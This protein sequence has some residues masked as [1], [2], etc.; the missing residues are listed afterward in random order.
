MATYY[1]RTGGVAGSDDLDL[2]ALATKTFSQWRVGGPNGGEA[3]GPP[4]AGD[5]VLSANAVSVPGLMGTLSVDTWTVQGNGTFGLS[6]INFI[7]GVLTIGTIVI[8]GIQNLGFAAEWSYNPYNPGDPDAQSPFAVLKVTQTP[9]ATSIGQGSIE[10]ATTIGANYKAT[11]APFAVEAAAGGVINA[12]TIA[13]DGADH[14]ISIVQGGM[15]NVSDA[16]NDYQSLTVSQAGTATINGTM[17]PAAD[18]KTGPWTN[19]ITVTDAR[20]VFTANATLMVGGGSAETGIRGTFTVQNGATANLNRD[21]TVGDKTLDVGIVSVTGKGSTLKIDGDLTLGNEGL[22]TMSLTNGAGLTVFGNVEEGAKAGAVL[23]S[24]ATAIN[25]AGVTADIHGDWKIGVAAAR[26]DTIGGGAAV[27]VD[28]ELNLG[29]K[30][31]G[32]GNLTV[33]GANTSLVISAGNAEVTIGGAGTGVFRLDQGTSFDAGASDVTVADEAGD[34]GQSQLDIDGAEMTAGNL[35]IGGGGDGNLTMENGAVLT[36]L[37]DLSLG[38]EDGSNYSAEIQQS[39]LSVAGDLTVGGAGTPGSGL[40]VS[41]A[42]D[43][44][45]LTGGNLLLNAAAVTA[46]ASLW[47][48]KTVAMACWS[49]TCPTSAA[50]GT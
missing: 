31:G 15:L 13:I 23:G 33:T 48:M 36:V 20:S 27:S 10:N 3:S 44:N 14:L 16:F 45:A 24:G 17:D 2:P 21:V 11:M 1:L 22:G 35:T 12:S 28:G 30:E 9:I 37:A 42:N 29:E 32:Q 6:G 47:V 18:S 8:A 19:T 40:P 7:N 46:A 39:F 34:G 4:G 50:P 5:A 38:D 43:P 26:N 49:P 25:G 41:G